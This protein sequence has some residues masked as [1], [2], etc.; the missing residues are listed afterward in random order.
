MRS[1]IFTTLMA[2]SAC[3]GPQPVA[4]DPPPRMCEDENYPFEKAPDFCESNSFGDCCTWT[5]DDAEGTV[6]RYDYCTY[7]NTGCEWVLTHEECSEE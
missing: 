6:C 5:L 3:A 7:H 1:I 2:M 4:D